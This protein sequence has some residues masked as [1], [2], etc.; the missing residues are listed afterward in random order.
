MC[1]KKAVVAACLLDEPVRYDAMPSEK[2][3][4]WAFS[5]DKVR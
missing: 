5:S 3:P 1:K 2:C 4:E